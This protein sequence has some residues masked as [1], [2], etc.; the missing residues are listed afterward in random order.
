MSSGHIGGDDAYGN[1]VDQSI[2]M[3]RFRA[4]EVSWR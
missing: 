3:D 1:K 4:D 2:V